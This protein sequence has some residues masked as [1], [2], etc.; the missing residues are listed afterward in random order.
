MIIAVD[1]GS[2]RAG[3]AVYDDHELTSAWLVKGDSWYDT[4][5]A[6]YDSLEGRYPAMFLP[7][8]EFV[9]E[10][11]QIYPEAPFD[12]NDLVTIAMMVASL[13]GYLQSYRVIE[14]LPKQWKGQVP[15]EIM[16]E[17]IWEKL[18]LE[19]RSRVELPR[20]KKHQLDV[21][22]AIGLGRHHLER[23]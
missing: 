9:L 7:H 18:S 5:R 23:T 4:A 6:A 16:F 10:R 15:K 12:Q 2:K 13:Q 14:Y 11:P 22:D 21:K 20:N 19:E 1:P 3:L 8:A 17:R